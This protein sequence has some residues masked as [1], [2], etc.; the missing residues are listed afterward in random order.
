MNMPCKPWAGPVDAGCASGG[1]MYRG[2]NGGLRHVKYSQLGNANGANNRMVMRVG[3]DC[4][5]GVGGRTP[6]QV[7]L[8]N[9][10]SK[11][12]V[13]SMLESCCGGGTATI[14]MEGKEH[15]DVVKREYSKL[16]AF[17]VLEVD[18]DGWVKDEEGVRVGKMCAVRGPEDLV[19]AE[20]LVESGLDYVVVEAMDWSIIPAENLIALFQNVRTKF[21]TVVKSVEEAKI[22]MEVLEC[23]A[24]GVV[25]E[26]ERGD[27]VRSLMGCIEA[28]AG[29]GK[30]VEYQIAR[31]TSIKQV[32]SGDRACVDLCEN[33]KPGEGMLCGSF[34]RCLFLVHSECEET[35]YINSRPFRVNAGPVH[36]Y[37]QVPGDRTKYLS[38]LQSG[39]QVEI[40]DAKGNARTATV[41]RV[42]IEKRP[43]LMVEAQGRD[44]G[45]YHSIMLQNAETVKL[46]GPSPESNLWKSI[47]VSQLKE[48]D[49]LFVVEHVEEA[50]RH[51]GVIINETIREV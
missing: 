9:V 25:M 30:G 14:L 31:V 27:D 21:L 4:G 1:M 32:G 35:S 19:E 49:E 11:D 50:A 2:V 10:K 13:T 28:L 22:M 5:G 46:V 40:Y 33:M 36:S 51:T 39:D 23:G 42:K 38:E 18:D 6:K 15:A 3:E 37:A 43:L 47:S 48:G 8:R 7:W 17:A 24:D 16:G 34:A 44:S 26:A 12:V 45:I 20:R 41:G 29:N